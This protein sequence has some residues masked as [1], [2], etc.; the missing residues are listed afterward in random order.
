MAADSESL[1]KAARRLIRGAGRAAL[2]TRAGADGWPYASLVLAACSHDAAPVLLISDLAE[3][4]RNLAGDPRASLLFDATAGLADPMTG[5]R[6]T[7]QGRLVRDDSPVLAARFVARHPSAADYAGFGDFHVWRM[8]P[9][10]AHLVAGFGRIHWIEAAELVHDAADA[11][12][13]AGAEAGIV[14]HMNADHREALNLYAARLVGR[15]GEGWTMTGI[16]P[17]GLDLRREGETARLDFDVA[18]HNAV[19]A[20]KI[21]V[22]LVAK[23]RANH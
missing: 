10:R 3:H 15:T 23:A 9:T 8:E 7:V 14:A 5:S 17:E 20:R 4:T 22:Q 1:G 6:L 18:V 16:D 21:L 19:E 13:L 12:P 11:A 2:A